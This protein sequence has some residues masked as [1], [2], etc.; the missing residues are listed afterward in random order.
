MP[1]SIY[2]CDFVNQE[3]CSLTIPATTQYGYDPNKDYR[4]TVMVEDYPDYTISVGDQVRSIRR[5]ISKIPTQ[6]SKFMYKNLPCFQLS[7]YICRT[8]IESF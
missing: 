1:M 3:T 6:V 5:P 8:H 4:V 7:N 2:L